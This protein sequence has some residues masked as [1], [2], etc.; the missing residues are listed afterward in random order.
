MHFY[1]KPTKK[2]EKLPSSAFP[3]S[4]TTQSS[5]GHLTC[6]LRNNELALYRTKLRWRRKII[7]D[8]LKMFSCSTLML[9][10]RCV[11]M[12]RAVVLKLVGGTEP[13][14]FYA[15]IHRTLR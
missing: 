10:W 14:K 1:I 8:L 7:M 3:K 11:V 9:D 6:N 2:Q 15:G 5:S 4:S 12:V 13:R